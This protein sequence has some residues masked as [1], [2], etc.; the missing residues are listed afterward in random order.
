MDN[1]NPQDPNQGGMG[2]DQPGGTPVADPNAGQ[3]VPE[4]PVAPEAPVAE[5][6]VAEEAPVA[7]E[8]PVAETP[9]V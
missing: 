4:T 8:A 6:P 9:A 2:G 7:P 5:T 3:S 1:Q